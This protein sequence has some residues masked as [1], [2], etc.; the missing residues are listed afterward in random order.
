MLLEIFQNIFFTFKFSVF[1]P[2]SSEPRDFQC[3]VCFWRDSPQWARASSFT[4]FLDHTQRRSTVGRTPLDEWSSRRRDL[5]L[6]THNTHNRQKSML[7]VGFEPT[8]PA[9]EWPQAYTL[10][11]DRLFQCYIFVN[12]VAGH[13]NFLIITYPNYSKH[14]QNETKRLLQETWTSRANFNI[15]AGTDLQFIKPSLCKCSHARSL[16]A[17]L[18][19]NTVSKSK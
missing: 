2:E 17:C 18:V 14:V 5:Y 12:M 1:F 10:D 6:T 19:C 8:T 16:C 11:W 3:C 4:R 7:P 15:L 13:S 9:A